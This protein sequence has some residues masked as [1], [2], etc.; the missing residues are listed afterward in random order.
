[1]HRILTTRKLQTMRARGKG[2]PMMVW[3]KDKSP[4]HLSPLGQM[5][6]QDVSIIRV[7]ASWSHRLSSC[8]YSRIHMHNTL[9]HLRT[10]APR[11][12]PPSGVEQISCWHA[13]SHSGK[14]IT[15]ANASDVV[16]PFP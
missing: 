13:H 5:A 9:A 7:A 6:R 11:H 15:H 4:Q 12:A 1:M 3:L 16:M 8:F 14:A 10:Q 2:L